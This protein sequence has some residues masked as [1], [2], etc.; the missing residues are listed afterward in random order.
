MNLKLRRYVQK[1]TLK[2]K[3]MTTHMKEYVFDEF[4]KSLNKGLIFKDSNIYTQFSLK[5]ELVNR[6]YESYFTKECVDLTGDL[7]RFFR[8][9]TRHVSHPQLMLCTMRNIARDYPTMKGIPAIEG[10]ICSEELQMLLDVT[11]SYFSE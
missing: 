9:F 2:R 7:S 8:A 1:S 11:N 6:F 10:Y 3:Y 4:I 5:N